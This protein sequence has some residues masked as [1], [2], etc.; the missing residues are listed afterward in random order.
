LSSLVAPR[1][2]YVQASGNA[3]KAKVVPGERLWIIATKATLSQDLAQVARVSIAS[4]GLYT[5]LP[6]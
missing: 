6:A 5:E 2:H 3:S 1:P 4:S